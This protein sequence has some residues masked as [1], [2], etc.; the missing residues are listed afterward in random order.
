MRFIF[1][2]PL[3]LIFALTQQSNAAIVHS[4]SVEARQLSS[5]DLAQQADTG[6][7]PAEI[8]EILDLHNKYRQKHHAPALEWDP[9]LAMRAQKRSN[10]CSFLLRKTSGEPLGE[11]PGENFVYDSR[12]FT[13]VIDNWYKEVQYYDFSKPGFQTF[14]GHFTLMV[15]KSTTTIGCGVQACNDSFRGAKFY[16]CYYS[17]SG[18]IMDANN[19]YYIE[20][21]LKP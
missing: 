1:A 3:L 2:T 20:N 13:V 12:T 6:V 21:V 14:T 4:S 8:K 10:T 19:Q 15:W 18:N 7:T 11:T 5:A 9:T 16:V 17:P